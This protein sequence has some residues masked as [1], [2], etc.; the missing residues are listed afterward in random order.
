VAAR[1]QPDPTTTKIRRF[2][3]ADLNQ[4]VANLATDGLRTSQQDVVGALVQ[5]ARSYPLDAVK[6]AIELYVRR[7][8]EEDEAE[9]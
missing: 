8:V 1:E 5:V 9:G 3:L 4:L 6:A 2:A 7:E